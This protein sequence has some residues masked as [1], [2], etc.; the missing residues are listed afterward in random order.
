MQHEEP[1]PV[2]IL[3]DPSTIGIEPDT[4]IPIIA[5]AEPRP[6]GI[7]RTQLSLL[8]LAWPLLIENV[9]RVA[10]TSADVIMLRYYSEEAVA[11]TGLITQFVFFINLLYLMVA[12]GASILISQNLGAH[13]AA[14]AG[15]VAM[16]SIVLSAAF[17]VLLSA[18]L[19]LGAESIVAFYT[20]D[21]LVHRYA[22]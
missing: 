10:I 1:R 3:T 16:G 11:A 17:S 20:L 2:P 8:H 4:H 7:D 9:I 13:N 22:M 5:D 6:P 18:A 12:S 14:A 15:R 19:C 21:P